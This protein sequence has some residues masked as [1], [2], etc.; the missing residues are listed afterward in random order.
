M[1]KPQLVEN[2]EVASTLNTIPQQAAQQPEVLKIEEEPELSPSLQYASEKVDVAFIESKAAIKD[3]VFKAHQAYKLDLRYGFMLSDKDLVFKNTSKSNN[4]V[5]FEA[6]DQN[7]KVIKRFNFSKTDYVVDLDIE[8]QNMSKLALPI[9]LPLYLGELDLSSKNVQ[10]RYY[11]VT[12]S[13]NEKTG[14]FSANKDLSLSAVKYI[15][16]RDRYFCVIVEPAESGYSGFIRKSNNHLSDIGLTSQEISLPA[17]Q[18]LV[19]KFR[20]YLGPQDL[21]LLNSIN[22]SWGY[23]I[24]YGTFDFIAQMILQT[25]EFLY[26]LVHNWGLAIIILSVLVYFILYPLTLK[27]MRSM[28]EMQLL[29]PKIEGLRKAYKDNPQ[30]LNKEIMELYKTHKVNPL[31]GCLPLILQMP[32][33]FALYQVLMRYVFLKGARFLWIKDLSEPDRLF[34]MPWSIPIL[35]NEFNI[36]PI[37]MAIG[38]FVQ[39]KMSMA[40]SASGSAAEQQKIMLV[41]MPIMFGVI[42]YHMPSG[43]VLYWFVNSALMLVYQLRMRGAK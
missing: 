27:Q 18:S 7:K 33:F 21:K 3:V 37:V 31:G 8:I 1:P 25:L 4:M 6:R 2:K 15:G 42:F 5:V 13:T 14:H 39:Q 16:F 23:L 9:S 43:L 40:G 20:I 29:Q 34:T 26:K 10:S 22:P 38:M 32:I 28:K 41:I 30:K 19:Q 35:G 36:L 24:N 11:D 12:V 17:G